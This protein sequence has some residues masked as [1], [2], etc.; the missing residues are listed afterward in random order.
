MAASEHLV[1]I[2]DIFVIYNIGRCTMCCIIYEKVFV[3]I[4][5]CTAGEHFVSQQ[6]ITF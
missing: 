2:K 5:H 3:M 1:N 6:H 4:L